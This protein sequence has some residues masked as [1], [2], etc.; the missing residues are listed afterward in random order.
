MISIVLIFPLYVFGLACYEIVIHD[1]FSTLKI[2][3]SKHTS[4][5]SYISLLLSDINY[6]F[7]HGELGV[8]YIYL[9]M[10]KEKQVPLILTNGS[11][12]LHTLAVVKTV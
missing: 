12:I 7:L 2:R 3:F 9:V 8:L 10:K 1:H 11:C 5:D 4:T 6:S